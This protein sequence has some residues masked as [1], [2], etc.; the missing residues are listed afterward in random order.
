MILDTVSHI[1]FFDGDGIAYSLANSGILGYD[2]YIAI[3][4]GYN[5]FTR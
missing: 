4:R 1:I 2:A 5:T 3:T